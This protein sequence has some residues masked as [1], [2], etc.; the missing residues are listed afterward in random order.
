MSHE[1]TDAEISQKQMAMEENQ[2]ET[3]YKHF[4]VIKV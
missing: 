3:A 1:K 4:F 2:L